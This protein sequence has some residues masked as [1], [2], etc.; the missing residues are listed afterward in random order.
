MHGADT[1]AEELRRRQK[2]WYCTR[3]T[4]PEE[5]LTESNAVREHV[6]EVYEMSYGKFWRAAGTDQSGSGF[7]YGPGF[8]AFADDFATGTRL[9]V[10]ARIEP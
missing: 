10:T 3:H 5:V 4:R 7:T 6:L 9:I 1:K 8:K 2:P